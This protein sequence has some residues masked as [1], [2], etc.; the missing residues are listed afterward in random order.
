MLFHVHLP[1]EYSTVGCA[2]SRTEAPTACASR[3][4]D[5]AHAVSAAFRRLAHPTSS[6]CSG[7]AQASLLEMLHHLGAQLGLLLR[8]PFAEPFARFETELA[9]RHKPLEIRRGPG[10]A[11][12]FRQHGLV[13]RERQVGPDEIRV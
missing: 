10:P 11:V 2:K 13:D 3:L 4:R 6:Y 5:F 8:R 7:I 1:G 9:L 12:D